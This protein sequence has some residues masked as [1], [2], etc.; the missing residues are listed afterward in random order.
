MALASLAPMCSAFVLGTTAA[1]AG[2][3]SPYLLQ[4]HFSLS[5]DTTAKLN[6]T[7]AT[8]L[9]ATNLVR[10]KGYSRKLVLRALNRRLI[11]RIARRATIYI[12]CVGFYLAC[13]VFKKDIDR[14]LDPST[15]LKNR[16][17]MGVAAGAD[18]V[19]IGAQAVIIAGMLSNIA[20]ALLPAALLAL[21]PAM[22]MGTADHV[23][24]TCALISCSAATWSVMR[25]EESPRE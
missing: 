12:P 24:L 4:Q 23:S 22:A 20:P 6:A 18:A 5:T 14:A 8:K 25:A 2:C 11:A 10:F 16:A 1:T 7:T 17:L 3:R 21:Q 13:K 19:D 15:D 9:N